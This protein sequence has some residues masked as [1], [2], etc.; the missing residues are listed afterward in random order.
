MPTTIGHS[1]A[2]FTDGD[3]LD[4]VSLEKQEE[5]SERRGTDGTV[6]KAKSFNP[7][8]DISIKGGGSSGLTIGLATVAVTGA[9][10]GVK[11]VR[12]DKFTEKNVDFNEHDAEVRH[13]PGAANQA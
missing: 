4:E 11:Y 1:I 3:Y 10:G 9:T 5:L 6:K 7:T 12:K 2:I 13:L 8:N